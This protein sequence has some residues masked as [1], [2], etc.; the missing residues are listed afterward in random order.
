MGQ[1][2][3]GSLTLEHCCS[4]LESWLLFLAGILSTIPASSG[5]ELPTETLYR[6]PQFRRKWPEFA[7][8]IRVKSLNLS[9]PAAQSKSELCLCAFS[10]T[11]HSIN[12]NFLSSSLQLSVSWS[13]NSQLKG[14]KL[15]PECSAVQMESISFSKQFNWIVTIFQYSLK[16]F[17]KNPLTHFSLLSSFCSSSRNSLWIARHTFNNRNFLVVFLV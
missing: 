2:P 15:P 7:S 11:M 5:A 9:K 16:N 14:V 10:R 6:I 12:E 13:R 8:D 1:N 4:W 17:L 3:E